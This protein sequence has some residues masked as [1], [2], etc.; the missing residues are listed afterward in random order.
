MV[1]VVHH[2]S[3]VRRIEDLGRRSILAGRNDVMRE[4]NP[5]VAQLRAVTLRA[6]AEIPDCTMR[7]SGFCLQETSW[8]AI[9]PLAELHT[10]T[11]C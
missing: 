1:V 5:L 2:A 9:Q 10:W 7:Q 8:H 11:D 4:E 6:K 3:A